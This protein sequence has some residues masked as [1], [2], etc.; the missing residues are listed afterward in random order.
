[1]LQELSPT[2]RKCFE[3]AKKQARR[4]GHSALLPAH[5]LLGLLER[6]KELFNDLLEPYRLDA[7]Q[8]A[9]A[10]ET[11]LQPA[12]GPSPPRLKVSNGVKSILKQS[13]NLA[14]GPVAPQPLAEQTWQPD[15]R[16]VSRIRVVA[17]AGQITFQKGA[18]P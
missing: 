2:S 3:A 14:N 16:D 15:W 17:H 4:L 8:V 7:D 12:Q 5:L 9:H 18:T 13:I 1:M 10:I 6:Q 11:R